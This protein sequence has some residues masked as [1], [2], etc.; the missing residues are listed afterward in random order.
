[1]TAAWEQLQLWKEI[2]KKS[3]K[4]AQEPFRQ[5][6]ET[7][8]RSWMPAIIDILD[9]GGEI[10]DFT[11]HDSG[12]AL[13]VAKRMVE[14]I[15]TATYKKLTVYERALLLLSAYLHDIGMTPKGGTVT[16]HFNYLLDKKPLPA[17]EDVQFQNW[18]DDFGAADPIPLTEGENGS[19]YDRAAY[20]VTHYCRHQ[21]NEWSAEWIRANVP[22][23]LPFSG[24]LDIL[25]QLCQSHHWDRDKLSSLQFFRVPGSGDPVN[26]RYLAL[27]LRVADVMEVDP[28]RVP[29]VIRNHREISPT[30]DTYWAK[31]LVT[32][33]ICSDCD[34]GRVVRFS[35]KPATARIH[36]ALVQTAEQIDQELAL[37]RA[38]SDEG[39]VAEGDKEETSRCEWTLPFSMHHTI[40]PLNHAYEYINGSFRPD[41]QRMLKILGGLELYGTALAAI[42]ELLQNAFDAVRWR[43]AEE[44]ARRREEDPDLDIEAH[45]DALRKAYGVDLRLEEADGKLYLVCRD[46][47]IGM[48]RTIIEKRLLV[49]SSGR[50]RD[51]TDLE[52]RCRAHGFSSELTGQFGIGALSYFLLAEEVEITTRA[53]NGEGRDGDAGGWRFVT[54]GL[55]DFGELKRAPS[56]PVGTTVRLRLH[57]VLKGEKEDIAATSIDGLRPVLEAYLRET[58]LRAPC[59]FT[60]RDPGGPRWRAS[61]GWTSRPEDFNQTFVANFTAQDRPDSIRTPQEEAA[62]QALKA[63]YLTQRKHAAGLIQHTIT[64][65]QLSSDDWLVQV[66]IILPTFILDEGEAL[67]FVPSASSSIYKEWADLNPVTQARLSW[68]GMYI[69]ETSLFDEY[70]LSKLRGR[71]TLHG[72]NIEIDILRCS[73]ATLA[74]HRNT[75][76]I[77]ANIKSELKQIVRAIARQQLSEKILSLL[78]TPLGELSAAIAY[79]SMEN[80]PPPGPQLWPSSNGLKPL[81]FPLARTFDRR[82]SSPREEQRLWNGENVR[83]FFPIGMRFP[84]G[85]EPAPQD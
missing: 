23:T 75:A 27:V 17:G 7:F 74:A 85:G 81:T 60:F 59:S 13:R 73:S 71:L 78:Q 66:R 65:K 40:E 32:S 51:E 64:E 1:M 67:C 76:R 5:A 26:L 21:H 61:P 11:L 55:G 84:G 28:E 69:E 30:S 33:L 37:A 42:R 8:V 16:R 80:L 48:T 35:A 36:H 20:L 4:P 77:P 14:L 62:H 49:S 19:R 72:N 12:H 54:Q 34:A 70:E 56:A 52:R 57:P 79:S 2:C 39:W 82:M 44:T 6:V 29:A 10:K 15:P 3:R 9:H 18:L 63:E 45:R 24:F 41:T 83:L 68:K 22:R 58:L 25:I 38:L 47:G 46:D 50:R 53:L 43:I 31:D